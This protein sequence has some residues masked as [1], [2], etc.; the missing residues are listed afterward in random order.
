MESIL[1]DLESKIRSALDK[2]QKSI[3]EMTQYMKGKCLSFRAVL[4]T[5]RSSLDFVKSGK[6]EKQEM[7]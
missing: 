6:S 7:L 2:V 3:S 4:N 1:S 5:I